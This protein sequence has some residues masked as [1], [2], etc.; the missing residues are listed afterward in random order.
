MCVVCLDRFS[1]FGVHL[2]ARSNTALAIV[3]LYCFVVQAY[4]EAAFAGPEFLQLLNP[5]GNDCIPNDPGCLFAT[6]NQAAWSDPDH[7]TAELYINRFV[8]I[9]VYL[10]CLDYV[11]GYG[12]KTANKLIKAL[13]KFFE[14]E[15]APVLSELIY[16]ECPEGKRSIMFAPISSSYVL[17][18]TSQLTTFALQ[19]SRSTP[20]GFIYSF[21]SPYDSDRKYCGHGAYYANGSLVN[22]GKGDDGIL[23]TKFTYGFDVIRYK[24]DNC[25]G[26]KLL[27]DDDLSAIITDVFA[28]GDFLGFLKDHYP[29]YDFIQDVDECSAVEPGQVTFA[30]TEEPTTKAPSS[31]PSVITLE[32]TFP[33]TT[34]VPTSLPSTSTPTSTPSQQPV[35]MPPTF[36][37]HP[38]KFIEPSASPSQ[39]LTPSRLPSMSP[40]SRE[41]TPFPTTSSPTYGSSDT[42]ELDVSIAVLH[43]LVMH[44]I[45]TYCL[46]FSFHCP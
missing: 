4:T 21:A 35:T 38:S 26:K 20:E 34:E 39:T 1:R 9:P 18:T 11:D 33:P 44:R 22:Q 30:P 46:V 19:S 10:K 37:S 14:V 16:D 23:I 27:E 32:P 29:E 36:S 17:H 6:A 13:D 41:P 7:C 31:S 43:L 15:V 12:P 2:N 28:D 42:G 45:V 8:D 40:S 5:P 25:K 24:P 3:L